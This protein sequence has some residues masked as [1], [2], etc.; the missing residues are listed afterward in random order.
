[1]GSIPEGER[2]RGEGNGHPLQYPCLGNSMGRGAW[3][4]SI[5]GVSKI[6]TGWAHTHMHQRH[7]HSNFVKIEVP[8]FSY[9]R[10]LEA[11]SLG[12]V[13]LRTQA[14][15]AFLLHHPGLEA[16][17]FYAWKLALMSLSARPIYQAGGQRRGKRRRLQCGCHLCLLP[18]EKVPRTSFLHITLAR[19]G[20]CILVTTY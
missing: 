3:W 12:L 7:S 19:T 18:P 20:C 5:H 15:S 14:P 17:C 6:R 4:A 2:P 9:N 11:E 8:F 10:R 16:F 1:M 13:Q